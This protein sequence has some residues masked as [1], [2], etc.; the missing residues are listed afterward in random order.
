M[1]PYV[2][3]PGESGPSDD[4]PEDPAE[5]ADRGLPLSGVRVLDLS[6]IIAGPFATMVLADLGADVIKVERSEVGDDPRRWGPPFHGTTAAY[7]TA[8]N[9]NRRS[10]EVDL[11]SLEGRQIVSAL[12]RAADVVVEN[13]LPA[14]AEK[15]GVTQIRAD[16]EA[17][18]VSL[19][20]AGSDGPDGAQP[21]VDAMVQARCGLMSVTGH[22][23]TGPVKV[24]VPIVD[25]LS[26]L[27]AA[28][29]ALAG[30][31]NRE[32]RGGAPHFEVP[33]LEVGISALVNQSAN[34]LVSGVVPEPMGNEHPNIVPYGPFPTAGGQIFLGA[35]SELQFGRLARMLDAP[36]LAEA[37]AFASNAS[38]VAHRKDLIEAISVQTRTRSTKAWLLAAAEHSVLAAP[39]NDVAQALAD[40]HVVATDL[41]TEV[42][43]AEGPLRMVGSPILVDG[44]RLPVR[45]PPPALGENTA[46]ILARLEA[47]PAGTRP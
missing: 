4:W 36:E 25:I 23:V 27:Y 39:V 18:W 37:A 30:M 32:R 28:V 24:G 22:Q 46:E 35:T 14:Q 2:D 1:D 40:P 44:Q 38:R 6:R 7:F 10:I 34:Y 15:L 43:T 29:A 9:R 31:V 42:D 47:R 21:G 33:L 41:V 12:A 13:F 17:V 3:R 16:T 26:G 11:T 20:G 8:V 19:R 5:S 45:R